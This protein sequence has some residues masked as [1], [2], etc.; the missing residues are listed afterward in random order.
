MIKSYTEILIT[1]CDALDEHIA[2]ERI[3]RSN[4]NFVYLILKAIAKGYEVII[5]IVNVLRNKFNP[6]SCSDAD[7]YSV[8]KIAGTEPLLGCGSG[9][10]IM[11]F[12]SSDTTNLIL[13]A[14]T[15]QFK[16]SDDVQFEFEITVDKTI[17]SLA[18][19]SFLAVSTKKGLYR[20]EAMS[21]MTITE[22]TGIIIPDDLKFSCQDNLSVLG[23]EDET[24][25]EFRKRILEDTT[26]QDALKELEIAIKN[27]PYI[28]DC[29]VLFNHTINPMSIDGIEVPPFHL[30]LVIHGAAKN[31][32]A[33][34][35]AKKTIYPTVVVNPENVLF[36]DSDIFIGGKY[37]VY[38]KMFGYK[39]FNIQVHYAYNSNFTT[40]T[41]IETAIAEA[42]LEFQN[43]SRYNRH[44]TEGEF[45]DVIRELK[46][47]GFKLLDVGLVVDGAGVSFIEVPPTKYGKVKD[48]MFTADDTL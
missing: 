44:F 30:L 46:L 6:A 10:Q 47:T 38:Y 34:I 7:L 13:K 40:R 28:F 8:A 27:L 16:L 19:T 26:R 4:E 12:N 39:E 36:Y 22:V 1:M 29:K 18:S 5:S 45:Y 9:L 3:T 20:V 37:P 21:S 42:M 17:N 24:T 11:A 25:L 2:P 43:P 32:I 31:E 15:Y 48:I 35:V 41:N 33:E 23:Y 14:G